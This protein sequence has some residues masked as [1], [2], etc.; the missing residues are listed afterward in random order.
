M[1]ERSPFDDDSTTRILVRTSTGLRPPS[2]GSAPSSVGRAP[3]ASVPI[4]RPDGLWDANDVA[5]YLKVSRSWVYHRAEAGLLSCIRVGGLL[6]F[7]PSAIRAAATGETTPIRR[8]AI[9]G[10]LKG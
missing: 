6:R 10:K 9:F 5:E 3:R 2:H 1:T 8:V 7:N 4:S